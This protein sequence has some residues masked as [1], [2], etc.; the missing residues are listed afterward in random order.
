LQFD[1]SQLNQ[2]EQT[3]EQKTL[4]DVINRFKNAETIGLVIYHWPY[5]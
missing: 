5:A 1:Q 3:I 4:P 2:I